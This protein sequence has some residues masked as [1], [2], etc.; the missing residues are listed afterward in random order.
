MRASD[1]GTQLRP[2]VAST[3]KH[4][5]LQI[6]ATPTSKTN[7]NPRD[8]RGFVLLLGSLVTWR[9]RSPAALRRFRLGTTSR[10]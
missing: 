4:S 1:S 10:V 2:Q 7:E 3:R 6:A 5:G 9:N 8:Q